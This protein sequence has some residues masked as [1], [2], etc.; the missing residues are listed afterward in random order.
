VKIKV[1]DC[2]GTEFTAD[3]EYQEQVIREAI[4][5]GCNDVSSVIVDYTDTERSDMDHDQYVTVAEDDGT[6]MWCGWLGGVEGPPPDSEADALYRERAH[7][8]SHLTVLY[9]SCIG[10]A[11]DVDEPG[12]ALVFVETSEGQMTWHIAP[13]DLDLFGHLQIRTPEWDGHT[14]AEK[15]RRL[16]ALTAT[17]GED[18]AEP[19]DAKPAPVLAASMAEARDLREHLEAER[20]HRHRAEARLRL[21]VEALQRLA[22]PAGITGSGDTAEEAQARLRCAQTALGRIEENTGHDRT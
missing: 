5:D 1:F 3:T 16:D 20:A 9:P 17:V 6:V 19:V 12:W 7:L 8:V 21:A 10:P 4:E 2:G 15:Y 13:R 22:D 11:P 18:L 14:T